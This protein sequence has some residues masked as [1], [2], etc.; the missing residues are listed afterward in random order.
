MADAEG[1][2]EAHLHVQHDEADDVRD[3]EPAPGPGHDEQPAS[4]EP[5]VDWDTQASEEPSRPSALRAA[6]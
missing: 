6:S 4:P 3:D 5:K 2:A 1:D